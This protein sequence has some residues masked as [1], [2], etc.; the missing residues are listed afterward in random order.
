ME[1]L[2]CPQC[3]A[4]LDESHVTGEVVHCAYCG[5]QFRVPRPQPAFQQQAQPYVFVETRTAPKAAIGLIAAMPI[6][7]V[8]VVCAFIGTI[9]YF[10]FTTIERTVGTAVNSAQR[11]ANDAQTAANSI[12]V[13]ANAAREKANAAAANAGRK[14]VNAA[15]LANVMFNTERQRANANA[16][17]SSGHAPVQ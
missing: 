17:K 3:G 1:T 5:T 4:Q 16:V 14:P 2:L 9:F 7:I 13:A 12:K 6:V 11:T 10:V 15:E 8:L